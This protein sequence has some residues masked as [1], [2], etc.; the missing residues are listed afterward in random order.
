[1][2]FE[3]RILAT[4]QK[5]EASHNKKEETAIRITYD[6]VFPSIKTIEEISAKDKKK[7][8]LH[9]RAKVNGGK[10][11]SIIKI[12][13]H[14]LIT[15]PTSKKEVI[16]K[17]ATEYFLH[18]HMYLKTDYF[19]KLK[20]LCEFAVLHN[21][22]AAQKF[23]RRRERFEHSDGNMIYSSAKPIHELC[24]WIGEIEER[25]VAELRA[26]EAQDI[27]QA[28][29]RL[30]S[31]LTSLGYERTSF[32]TEKYKNDQ[33][34]E[35]ADKKYNII[36]RRIAEGGDK[37]AKDKQAE[38]DEQRAVRFKNCDESLLEPIPGTAT[39]SSVSP[40]RQAYELE[41]GRP[42]KEP[43]TKSRRKEK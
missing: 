19:E 6:K 5:I 7:T 1:M 17:Y 32:N 9:V 42:V 22:L 39:K 16:E 2:N 23:D 4:K 3:E 35:F 33:V 21:Q 25:G 24:D 41:C 8:T 13:L 40:C 37:S 36:R 43:K 28:V 12:K 11:N 30:E 14:K 34:A 29:A 27:Q 31:I 38:L 10:S 26:D 20:P 18:E 15:A